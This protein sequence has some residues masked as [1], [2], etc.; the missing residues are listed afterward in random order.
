MCVT[1]AQ[2]SFGRLKVSVLSCQRLPARDLKDIDDVYVS[3]PFCMPPK[4]VTLAIWAR[5]ALLANDLFADVDVNRLL[6]K[7][8]VRARTLQVCG[9][10]LLHC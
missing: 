1:T 2:L 6:L 7:C 4:L 3:H 8:M 5:L 9:T 10:D